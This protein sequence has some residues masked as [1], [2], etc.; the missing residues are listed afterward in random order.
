MPNNS[1]KSFTI[2][3]VI[4]LMLAVASPSFAQSRG[5]YR[6][7]AY[8]RAQVDHLIRQVENRSDQFVAIFDRALDRSRLEGTRRED[9]LNERAI[10]LER[11]LNMV[12]REFNRT[13]NYYD[14]RPHVARTLNLAQQINNVMHNRRLAPIAERQWA[15]LRSDLNRLAVAYNLRQLR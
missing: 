5:P 6:G 12:R 1:L 8:T 4:G 2:L 3:A 13:G 11:E 14:V 9:R 7:R 15:L 10:N